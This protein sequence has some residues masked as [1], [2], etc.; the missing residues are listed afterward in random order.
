MQ[1][2][3]KYSTFIIFVKKNTDNATLQLQWNQLV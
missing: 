1:M 3:Q 2:S